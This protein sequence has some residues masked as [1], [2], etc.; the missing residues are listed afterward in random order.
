MRQF[1]S[2]KEKYGENHE[3]RLNHPVGCPSGEKAATPSW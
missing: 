3:E 2:C 1:L